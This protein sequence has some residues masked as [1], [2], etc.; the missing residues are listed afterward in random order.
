MKWGYRLLKVGVAL[1]CCGMMGVSPALAKLPGFDYTQM[2]D[3]SDSDPNAETV[4]SGDTI[5]IGLVEAFSGP[6][7]IVGQYYR[8]STHWVAHDINKRGGILVDGKMKKVQIVLG[9]SLG[10][11]SIVKKAAERLILKDKVDVLWGTSGSHAAKIMAQVAKKYKTL[12]IN[13][14]SLAD[15]LHDGKNFNRYTFR[16]TLNTTMVG[17]SLAYFYSKRPEKKFYILNQDY[18]FGHSLAGAFKDALK[19]FKPDAQ[20]VGESYH[21]LFTKDYAPYITKV[22]ATDAEVI[23]T[24]DWD[25]DASNLIR[26]ARGLGL[27]LPFANIY[28]DSVITLRAIGPEAGI[29]Q[30]NTN[31]HMITVDT[32]A[33]NHY[34]KVWNAAW[35][36]GWEKPYNSITYKWPGTIFGRTSEATYWLLDVMRRA[37]T[38]DTEKVIKQ[39]EGDKWVGLTGVLEMR[40]CDHQVARDLFVT[41]F[42]FPN[43]W[44]PDAASY[45]KPIVMPRDIAVSS[46][47]KD[48]KRCNQ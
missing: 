37:G 14:M 2:S 46:V 32:P 36:K 38:T 39:R 48:L 35:K 16:T 29:G 33:N 43:K 10:K 44:F 40:A 42:I 25:P 30:V 47:P 13:P 26:Q 6:A 45:G 24:G 23:S 31:D 11:P 15:S 7:A 20:I 1:F 8:I 5:K 9:N 17:R 3:M 21:P 34:N 4:Q 22:K 19:E 28:A 41:E 18:L 27:K 12:M